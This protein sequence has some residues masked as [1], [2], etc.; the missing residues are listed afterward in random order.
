MRK[1]ILERRF[2]AALGFDLLAAVLARTATR[3]DDLFLGDNYVSGISYTDNSSS[4]TMGSDSIV[5]STSFKVSFYV[6]WRAGGRSQY[7]GSDSRAFLSVV[8]SSGG[9][10]DA[11]R[12]PHAGRN[13]AEFISRP[14][15]WQP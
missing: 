8:V 3:A 12:A 15:R 1:L 13:P 2:G 5:T 6:F 11:V 10:A 4:N 7:G 14:D 9:G